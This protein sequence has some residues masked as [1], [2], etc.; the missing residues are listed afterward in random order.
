MVKKRFEGIIRLYEKNI[1]LKDLSY[2]L[3]VDI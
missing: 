3:I 2:H 1:Y